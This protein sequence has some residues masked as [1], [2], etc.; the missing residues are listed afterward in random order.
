M[1]RPRAA[2]SV[3]NIS[4]H[5]QGGEATE[6]AA[7]GGASAEAPRLHCGVRAA[8]AAHTLRAQRAAVREGKRLALLLPRRRVWAF[9]RAGL[10]VCRETAQRRLALGLLLVA[11]HAARA[12][13][14]L[15][16]DLVRGG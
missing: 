1:S 15:P 7:G 5:L 11:V 8:R 6:L 3:A 2:T 13:A 4:G 9:D 16:E 10:L 14:V 12:E